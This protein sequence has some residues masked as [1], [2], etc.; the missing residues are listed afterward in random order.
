[1]KKPTAIVVICLA[2]SSCKFAQFGQTQRNKPFVEPIQTKSAPVQSLLPTFQASSFD[3]ELPPK[4][5]EI[6]ENAEKF[7]VYSFVSGVESKRKAKLDIGFL[8]FSANKTALIS[9]KNEQKELLDAI[10]QDVKSDA[11]AAACWTPHHGIKAT[12]KKQTVTLAI[13]F[14]WRHFHGKSPGAS[15][16][17]TFSEKNSLAVFDRLVEKY[18]AEVK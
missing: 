7:E 9:D 14:R 6:L 1:M 12:Y 17:G 8:P 2:L 11:Y 3:E 4:A 18:G 15:F 10:Y 13:C 16:G 5:R